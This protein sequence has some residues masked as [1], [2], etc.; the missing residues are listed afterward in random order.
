M[1]KPSKE[2]DTFLNEA[3]RQ[4]VVDVSRHSIAFFQ[5]R[6]EPALVGKLIQLKGEHRLVS[7]RLRQ[8][9]LLGPV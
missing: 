5:D 7:K 3:L 8:F 9:N 6:G 2:L 4:C 1:Q